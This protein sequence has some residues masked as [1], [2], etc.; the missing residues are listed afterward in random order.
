[1]SEIWIKTSNT[2]TTRW[3]KATAIHIKRLSAA[4]SAAKNVWIK[5]GT[6]SWLRVWPLSGV[7]ATSSPYITTTASGS[8]PIYF[9]SA[10]IRIGTT[11]YGRN[12]TWDANGWTISSYSY[13]WPYYTSGTAG[14]TDQIGTLATG[15]YT[16]PSETLT[17]SSAANATAVDGKYISFRVTANASN[18]AYSGTADSEA[19]YGRSKVIRRTPLNISSSLTGT[20]SVGQTLTYGSSWN[21]TEAYKINTT[22][23]TMKWYKSTSNTDIYE[24]GSRTEITRASGSYTITLAAGDSLDGYYVIAEESVYNTGSDHDIGL[25]LT[26]KDLNR[27]TKVTASPVLSPYVFTFGNTLYVGTNGYISLDSANT[28]DAISSTAGKVLSILSGDQYQTTT[29]SIWY[30]SNTT[31]FRI[32]WEGHRYQA[33]TELRQYE[34]IFYKDQSYATVYAISVSGAAPG[35]AAFVKDGSALTNYPSALTTGSAY[36]VNFNGTTAP[37][38]FIGYSPKP[39]GVMVQVGGLTGGSQDVGYTAITSAINQS[40]TPT[41]GAFDIASFTKG[42]VSSSSQGAT[43]STTLTWNESSGAER[44][45]I[46]YQGS[47]DNVNWTTVQTYAGSAYNTGTSETKNWSTTGGNFSFYTFMRANIRASETTGTATDV[48]SNA[49]SYVEAS[50]TA[51]GQVSFGTITKT[52]TTASIPFTVGTQGSHYLDSSIEYQYRISS[53]SYSGT[54]ST[55]VITSSAG[56]IS[57][58]GLTSSTTYYIKIRVRN[59]DNIY[60]TENETNFATNAG[61][62]SPTISSVS[63]ST[64]N[65][66]WTVNYTGGS[67]PF[68]Q[69]WYQ[70]VQITSVPALTGTVS[71]GADAQSN[72]AS[73]TSKVLGATETYVYWWWVRSSNTL[74]GS[75]AGNVSDWNGPVTASPINTAAPTLTGTTK[76]GNTLTYGKGTWLN[77]SSTTTQLYR[78]TAGVNQSET[79][80]TSTTSASSTYTIP[81]SDFTDANN[82]KYYRSF[83]RGENASFNA[84]YVAGTEL[85]PL[86]NVVLYTITFDSKSGSAV[87]ALTQSTEG[88]SIAKPTDPTR[89]DFTFG[90]WTTTDGGTTAVTWPRTPT[91]N[92]TLYAKWNAVNSYTVTYSANGGGGATVPSSQTTSGSITTAAV[93]AFTRTNCTLGSG[94][95]TAANGSG[96]NVSA[97]ASYTPT[98]DVTLYA[99]WTAVANSHTAPPGFKFDGNNLPSSG[100][101]RWSWTGTGT[102]TGGSRTGF[103]VEIATSEFGTYTQASGSPLPTTARTYDIAVSPVT[104]ARWV[105]ICA[106]YT[107]GL[108]VTRFGDF[109]AA[110]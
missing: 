51:P 50:G 66:T 24:G 97:S 102:L 69:I 26:T 110:K 33:P 35:V 41:L 32:R 12:G 55:S 14:E 77:A 48:Y 13:A 20:P 60:S 58:S 72:S 8:T 81:S 89:T 92:E 27:I 56:T 25:D 71:S 67:G 107:D 64:S 75:G 90:G 1:M 93:P 105:K 85:G 39:K 74:T 43:R 68:Y 11:Y 49:G 88:G 46:Q 47:N 31:E 80:V 21:T 34:V 70:P 99:K 109:T 45:K 57:L 59:Q 96:T 36:N 76:V 7:F 52:G 103:R 10:P 29:T 98:A 18:A 63:Y 19:T 101:K 2:G 4:W 65:S 40:V 104:S 91:A 86:T 87:S 79:F 108:G 38:T 15:T 44:Y 37:I 83:S 82:R 22:R 106:I 17:I 78:G 28:S 100:R 61:L 30:W 6:S 95:N 5:T 53:G 73:S 9:D 84:S 16:A 54:W 62:S 23:S 94:W 42:T 3:R